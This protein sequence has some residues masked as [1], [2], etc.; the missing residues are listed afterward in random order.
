MVTGVESWQE[1]DNNNLI[2][3]NDLAPNLVGG[4]S[5]QA[6]NVSQ[7]ENLWPPRKLA[8]RERV[9]TWWLPAIRAGFHFGA[10]ADIDRNV[11]T[12]PLPIVV[13][14]HRIAYL[15][16]SGNPRD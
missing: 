14:I 15:R 7:T 13:G 8:E 1:K 4:R 10:I 2:R 16:F 6:R 3:G 11:A 9:L 5:I 12:C